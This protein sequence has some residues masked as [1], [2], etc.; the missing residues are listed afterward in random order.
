M[1]GS[2]LSRDTIDGY[3]E[4]LGRSGR[5]SGDGLIRRAGDTL[6]EACYGFTERSEARLNS[7]STAF[8]IASISKQFSAASILLLQ[9]RQRLTVHDA[10]G[11][12]RPRCPRRGGPSPSIS[13]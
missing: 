7:P 10:I 8:Q 2:H 13:C 4:E 5:F 11:A 6:L 3:V 9:E 12:W 1:D